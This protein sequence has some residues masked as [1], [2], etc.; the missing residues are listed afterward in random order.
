MVDLRCSPIP[1]PDLGLYPEVQ[2]KAQKE[3]DSVIG[4]DRLPALSDQPH[5]PYLCHIVSEM[6]RWTH[7]APLG[8]VE[9]VYKLDVLLIFAKGLAHELQKDD[10]Y[11]GMYIPAK[12]LVMANTWCVEKF[13]TQQVS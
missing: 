6:L 13:R 12:S 2:R 4:S 11:N 9:F 8:T 7:S 10:F 5:L 1:F 3:I